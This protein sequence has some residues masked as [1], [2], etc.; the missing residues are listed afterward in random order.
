M[1]QAELARR[2]GT[3]QA[4]LARYEGGSL[5]PRLE[6]LTRLL[7]ASGHHLVLTAQPQVRRGAVA[8]SR[9]SGE[10]RDILGIEGEKG[11]WR[12]LLDFVDDFRG[13]SVAGKRSLVAEP[14]PLC[15][16]PRLN[17]AVAGIVDFLCAEARLAAPSWTGEDARVVEPWWFVSGLRGFE[18]MA[19]RDT[20]A[21]L[22]R[23]GVFVNEGAFDRV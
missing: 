4:T 18:A 13:S 21:V 12:R 10:I 20:P 17:A 5:V 19:L 6:T 23:H 15:G 9:V 2:S 22:A 8:I 3:S 16:D 7:E 11:A 14:A 1:T